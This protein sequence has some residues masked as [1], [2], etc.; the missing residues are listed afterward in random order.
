MNQIQINNIDD[1]IK[2]IKRKEISVNDA[3]NV[4]EKCLNVICIIIVDANTGLDNIKRTQLID[5]AEKIAIELKKD[6]K[7]KPDPILFR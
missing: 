7:Y 1:L 6:R 2:F 4:F 3:L 5:E